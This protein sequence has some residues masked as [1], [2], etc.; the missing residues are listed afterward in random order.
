[1]KN[2]IVAGQSAVKQHLRNGA[3]TACNR[4]FS[5]NTNDFESFKYWAEKH[6]EI[7]CSKCLNRFIQ[8]IK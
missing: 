4:K 6:S 5:L 7:C 8:K 2:N 1:M 3:Y